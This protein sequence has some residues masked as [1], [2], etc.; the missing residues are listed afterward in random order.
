ML[1]RLVFAFAQQWF[2]L[3]ITVCFMS[4]LKLHSELLAFRKILYAET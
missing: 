3:V 1:F 2:S 4:L